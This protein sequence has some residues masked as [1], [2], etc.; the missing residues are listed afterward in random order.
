MKD[1]IMLSKYRLFTFKT[2]IVILVHSVHGS[3]GTCRFF[4][5][6]SLFALLYNA[7]ILIYQ[8]ARTSGTLCSN[9]Y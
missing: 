5:F 9:K 3:V 6:E 1:W 2:S 8:H 7:N 4:C